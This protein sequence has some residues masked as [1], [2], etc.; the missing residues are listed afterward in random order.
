MRPDPEEIKIEI[1]MGNKI[2]ALPQIFAIA[3]LI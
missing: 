3:S 2:R 1:C